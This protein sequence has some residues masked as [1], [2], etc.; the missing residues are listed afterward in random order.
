MNTEINTLIL[1]AAEMV[2]IVNTESLVSWGLR[3]LYFVPVALSMLSEHSYLKVY[4]IKVITLIYECK[5][6]CIWGTFFFL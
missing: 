1:L 2:M 5:V 6:I 3:L 4:N